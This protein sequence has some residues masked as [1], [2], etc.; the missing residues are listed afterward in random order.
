[1]SFVGSNTNVYLPA[2]LP[3]MGRSFIFVMYMLSVYNEIL[4][5]IYVY[6]ILICY[7]NGY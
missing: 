3:F 7:V 2:L 5:C 6:K 1:M 4:I